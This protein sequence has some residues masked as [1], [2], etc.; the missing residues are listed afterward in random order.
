MERWRS[1]KAQDFGQRGSRVSRLSQPQAA[2]V[3]TPTGAGFGGCA[4]V[5][6]R[7][8][9]SAEVAAHVGEVFAAQF[10]VQPGFDVLKNGASPGELP[11]P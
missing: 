1:A 9:S 10:G 6:V 8:G 11:G 5:L 7:L 2:T 3:L 4:I